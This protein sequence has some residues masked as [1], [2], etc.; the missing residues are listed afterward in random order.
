[1]QIE[2]YDGQFDDARYALALAQTAAL[3]N[4]V[5]LNHFTCV[6]LMRDGEGRVLG[7]RVRDNETGEAVAVHARVVVNATGP[8]SDSVRAMADA[9][10]TEMIMPSSGASAHA[11]VSAAASTAVGSPLPDSPISLQL[12]PGRP[13]QPPT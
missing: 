12:W 7:A 3:H 6:S 11:L 13:T 9:D 8:F 4:A 2:Y 5:V 10:A 1:M